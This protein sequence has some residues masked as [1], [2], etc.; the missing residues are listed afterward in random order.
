[1]Q[2]PGHVSLVDS[3]LASDFLVAHSSA[4]AY[5]FAIMNKPSV[6]LDLGALNRL[7]LELSHPF[8]LN[9]VFPSYRQL[10]RRYAIEPGSDKRIFL[11]SKRLVELM[12][13]Q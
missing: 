12:S 7:R 4:A 5:E 1:V 6:L 8:G 2:D 9:F 11:G 10:L 3:I 13:A